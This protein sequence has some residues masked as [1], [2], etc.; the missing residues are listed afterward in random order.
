VDEILK[1]LNSSGRCHIWA[2]ATIYDFSTDKFL[3]SAVLLL[4]RWETW[5]LI[6]IDIVLGALYFT[7]S[8]NLSVEITPFFITLFSELNDLCL[9]VLQIFDICNHH[10]ERL[11]EN[12]TNQKK[13][14]QRSPKTD[15][16][17]FILLVVL[18]VLAALV[19][20]H[21]KIPNYV[22]LLTVGL[23]SA[24]LVIAMHLIE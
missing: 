21:Y 14:L 24:A 5:G 19:V 10:V 18:W 1:L 2:I 17:H 16:Y 9:L 7:F 3:S 6:F 23:L 8:G 12:K 15:T 4:L 13:Q 20:M 22:H 11:V